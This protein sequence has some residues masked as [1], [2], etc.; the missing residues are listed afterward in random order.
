MYMEYIWATSRSKWVRKPH[1]KIKGCI[2]C[3]IARGDKKIP[4]K[5]VYK[6][7]DMMVVMNI[8]PYNPGHLQVVPINHVKNLEDLSE[9]EFN[10]FFR[11]GKKCIM[12]LKKALNQAG[13]NIGINIGEVAGASIE[14]LHM[15]IVPRYTREVGFMETT[16]HTKVMPE[17]LDQTHKRLMKFVD[18]LKD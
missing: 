12:L 3:G 13:F 14:H 4:A 17:S 8:F 10:K 18:I 11:M 5:V 15:Q 2:F 1:K 6:D 16:S 7:K 9:D